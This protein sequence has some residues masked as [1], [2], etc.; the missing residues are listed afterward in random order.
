MAWRSSGASNQALI[1]NLASNGL[2]TQGRVK[3]AMLG[4]S[5]PLYRLPFFPTSPV[6]PFTTTG[7]VLPRRETAPHASKPLRLPFSLSL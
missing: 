2:I 6:L 5:L 3:Q 1:E 4:V 7:R